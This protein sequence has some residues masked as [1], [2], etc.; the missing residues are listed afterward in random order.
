MKSRILRWGDSRISLVITRL[1]IRRRQECQR[2]RCD[3][4]AEV[5]LRER[6]GCHAA[7]FESGGR[8]YKLRNADSF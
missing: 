7:G 3:N 6:S 4:K 1:L 5:R 2:K 8:G